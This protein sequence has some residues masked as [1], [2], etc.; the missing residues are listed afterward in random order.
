MIIAI[1]IIVGLW[2]QPIVGMFFHEWWH[3]KFHG[4][5]EEVKQLK[6]K[7]TQQEI[8][9]Q[10]LQRNLAIC[11]DEN[12]NLRRQLTPPPPTCEVTN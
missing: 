7:I 8:E 4:D 3:K 1:A 10:T 5:A 9:H 12:T 2:T 6:A 11:Y